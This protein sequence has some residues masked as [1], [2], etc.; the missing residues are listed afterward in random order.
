MQQLKEL[1]SGMRAAYAR[2]ENAMEYARRVTHSSNNSVLAT[3]I[4]YDLQTGSYNQLVTA[5]PGR[6]RQW[7]EQLGATLRPILGGH[8]RTVLEVGCGEATT[9]TGVL[10]RLADL[11][12]QGFGF[13]VSWSR[14]AEGNQWLAQHDV[15]ARL[16]VADLFAIPLANDSIDVVYTSHSLEPNGGRER[17][18]V[19][20]LLRVARSFVV[21]FEPIYELAN[22]EAQSRMQRHGYV[23]DLKATAEKL[24]AKVIDYRLLPYTQ[25]PLN[26]SG[27]IVLA[28]P[29]TAKR[30]SDE[31][32][33]WRCPLTDTPLEETGDALF[34]P[35]MGIAY[36]VLEGIP[37]LRAEHAVVASR[38]RKPNAR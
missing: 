20:E 4:A 9:L 36:P 3:L 24:G 25:N 5:D 33:R 6:F 14:C 7:E 29:A 38:F 10:R 15:S 35:S 13:D 31:N 27:V 1:I 11:S 2:G 30:N 16:F 23:R 8:S 19:D 22:P 18:A 26:P 12:L 34:S 28:K 37:L 32:P 17:D 21:L